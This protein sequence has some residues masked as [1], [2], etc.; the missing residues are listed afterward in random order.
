MATRPELGALLPQPGRPRGSQTHKDV[1]GPSD[2][3]GRAYTG[4]RALGLRGCKAVHS[5]VLSCLVFSDFLWQPGR[6]N[7]PLILGNDKCSETEKI[8]R[9]RM[10]AAQR[11][12]E[13]VGPGADL[14]GL[15]GRRRV[16]ASTLGEGVPV[17]GGSER[18]DLHVHTSVDR[19]VGTGCRGRCGCQGEGPYP[20]TVVMRA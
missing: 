18:H 7:A 12:Q 4:R 8:E 5:Y 17:A 19:Y 9:M 16:Q 2:G 1:P 11:E 20:G 3:A 15:A 10:G 14:E 6:A 13:A